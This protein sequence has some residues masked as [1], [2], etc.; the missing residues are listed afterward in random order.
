MKNEDAVFTPKEG[1]F[2]LYLSGVD[3]LDATHEMYNLSEVFET[4]ESYGIPK[5]RSPEVFC[6][7]DYFLDWINYTMKWRSIEI[8]EVIQIIDDEILVHPILAQYYLTI[9]DAETAMS[10]QFWTKYAKECD[11]DEF[12]IEEM[13]LENERILIEYYGESGHW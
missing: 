6:S 8:E 12:D 9:M 5:E 2:K 10:E 11:D 1:C 3:I 4:F 13:L 7:S